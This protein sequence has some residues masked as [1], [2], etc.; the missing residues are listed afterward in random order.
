MKPWSI[1]G[2]WPA[3]SGLRLCT[4]G[5]SGRFR[6]LVLFHICGAESGWCCLNHVSAAFFLWPS[7][8]HEGP[9]WHTVLQETQSGSFTI[10]RWSSWNTATHAAAKQITFQS[11]VF[12]FHLLQRVLLLHHSKEENIVL[13]T[14]VQFSQIQLL[15]TEISIQ[16]IKLVHLILYFHQINHVKL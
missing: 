2:W 15:I 5:S 3:R 13:F 1:F 11:V 12:T 4:C 16:N 7:G 10:D 14:P 9:H 6:C 8:S